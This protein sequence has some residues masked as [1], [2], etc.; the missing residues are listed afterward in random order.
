MRAKYLLLAI[1]A[2]VTTSMGCQKITDVPSVVI[3]GQSIRANAEG[4]VMTIAVNS[5]GVDDVE[6][7]FDNSWEQDENGD[8]YPTEE[9]IPF[10]RIVNHY[11]ENAT[12]DLATWTSGI[13]I[14]IKP[15]NTGHERK[16]TIE[17]ISF[18]VSDKIE[19]IQPSL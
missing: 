2:M 9:W 16:A 19:I 8:L 7:D 3:D 11:D 15:N 18:S 4:G 1:A 13:E 14:T 5:T 12:R 10:N 6:I 17:V